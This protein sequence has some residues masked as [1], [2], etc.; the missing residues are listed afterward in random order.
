M[1][2]RGTT[3]RLSLIVA[4]QQPS[5]IDA[6]LLSQCDLI[7]AHKITTWDDI[8]ALDRL[9]ATY[10]KGNLKGYIRQLNRRGEALLVDDETESVNTIRVR[11]RRSAHGGAEIQE[12]QRNVLFFK[13]H[14]KYASL[15]INL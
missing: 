7:M 14:Y 15:K 13:V 2:E 9:S 4:T 11:P 6:E 8:N 5:A 10:M 3:A 1:G 12:K